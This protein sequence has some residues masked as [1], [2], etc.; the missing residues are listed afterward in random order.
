MAYL[1]TK[2]KDG[3]NYYYIVEGRRV[4]G[5]VKQTV[6]EYIGTEENLKKFVVEQYMRAQSVEDGSPSP[7]AGYSFESYTHGAPFAL[8]RVAEII[9]MEDAMK[10]VFPPRIIRGF[11]RERL[12]LLSMLQRAVCPASR[13]AFSSWAST[14]SLPY[15]LNFNA[16]DIDA[17]A[18]REAMDGITDE[19]IKS[20]WSKIV[21][22]VLQIT[23]AP[24]DVFHLDCTNIVTVVDSKAGP[25]LVCRR[26]PQRQKGED[27]QQ[28]RLTALT[29]A[30]LQIPLVW[31]IVDAS[32]CDSAEFADFT[33]L[34][35]QE[36][37]RYKLNTEDITLV[38]DDDICS[39]REFAELGMQVICAHSL[40]EQQHLTEIDLEQYDNVEMMP[41]KEKLAYR[42][43]NMTFSGLDGVGILTF[44]KDLKESQLAEL[45]RDIARLKAE[46]ADITGLLSD[47]ASGLY[48]DL[49]QEKDAVEFENDKEVRKLKTLPV[50]NELGTMKKIVEE[51]LFKGMD[52]LKQFV[53]VL[54]EKN[55]DGRY[56]CQL[57]FSEKKKKAYIFR[58]FGKKLF[59]STRKEWMNIPVQRSRLSGVA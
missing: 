35:R 38:F 10:E 32:K 24:L 43:E 7:A 59:C 51:K 40:A 45:D 8:F 48:A 39:Q 22:N 5:K 53:S 11:P 52:P 18:F 49:N 44:S 4:D 55:S 54:I 6:L 41:G 34:I 23:G 36:I 1:R 28:F 27:L 50:D 56:Q 16:E 47:P 9:R 19:Q 31:E 57:E 46:F 42:I 20:V 58:H 33:K 25:C 30:D 12:L 14:T 37:S 3:H 13:R 29:N 2:S 17:A 21:Q 15:H 26:D